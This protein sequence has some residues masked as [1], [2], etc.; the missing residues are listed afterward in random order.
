MN[1]D[2]Y[3]NAHTHTPAPNAVINA[4]MA[5]VDF[6]PQLL[7]SIGIHPWD[8]LQYCENAER[9]QHWLRTAAALPQVVAIGECG[10]DRAIETE[11]ELQEDVFRLQV[12]VAQEYQKTLIIHCVRAYNDILKVLKQTKCTQPVV[13][14]KFTGNMQTYESFRNF[15]C[16]YSFGAELCTRTKSVEMLRT[17]PLERIVFENDISNVS[18]QEIYDF[19]ARQIGISVEMLCET[20]QRSAE[21]IFSVSNR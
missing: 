8:Y 16:Y 5:S 4:P 14:H 11:I 18:M 7:Y 3:F 6:E 1:T 19:A 15:D 9:L 2:L 10:M 17:L 12:K 20:V 21:R 13:F